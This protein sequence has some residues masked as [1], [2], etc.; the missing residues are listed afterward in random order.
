MKI[1]PYT[2]ILLLFSMSTFATNKTMSII[3]DSEINELTNKNCFKDWTD[4]LEQK[5]YLISYHPVKKQEQNLKTYKSIL[6]EYSPDTLFFLGDL[7][8]PKLDLIQK[9]LKDRSK[10]II[11]KTETIFPLFSE[12]KFPHQGKDISN[13]YMRSLKTSVGVLNLIF[14]RA[15][16]YS[17]KG[18]IHQYCEYF[19]KSLRYK[20]CERA[21]K[22]N[23]AS[24]VD[25]DFT[26]LEND[27]YQ[28]SSHAKKY[29]H[30]TDILQKDNL[31]FAFIAAHA[32]SKKIYYGK[33]ENK[34]TLSVGSLVKMN[35]STRFLNLYSCRV[36]EDNSKY[37][38]G[39]AFIGSKSKTLGVIGSTK[40][41]ALAYPKIFFDLLKKGYTFSDA[42]MRY[43][44]FYATSYGVRNSY[45]D[46]NGNHGGL[47]F[48]GDPTLSLHTCRDE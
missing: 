20:N 8:L 24:M 28:L 36:F 23:I 47:I 2:L 39:K 29:S 10:N 16:N 3:L 21:D 42:L 6:K 15:P 35:I 5:G 1:T 40:T 44:R 18:L 45:L 27:I 22:L 14:H 34:Q 26:Q 19:K 4:D 43:T 7:K 37:S 13:S 48:Y 41:G 30:L 46:N 38:I 33:G 32:N 25:K 12:N 17:K 9:N 11:V 31:D